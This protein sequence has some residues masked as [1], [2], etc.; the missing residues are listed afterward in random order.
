MTSATYAPNKCALDN[1]RNSSHVAIMNITSL[2][3]Y[4]TFFPA[5]A[6]CVVRSQERV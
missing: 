6:M 1:F 5:D 3:V 4:W 2:T